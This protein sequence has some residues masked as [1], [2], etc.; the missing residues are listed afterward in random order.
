MKRPS[1]LTIAT[2][3]GLTSG[4]IDVASIANRSFLGAGAGDQATSDPIDFGIVTDQSGNSLRMWIAHNSLGDSTF[5][6]G[7]TTLFCVHDTGNNFPVIP[8]GAKNITI[9][10]H[11]AG[12]FN[13]S[14]VAA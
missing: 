11:A 14:G 4:I 7:V 1:L 8:D 2:L 3:L 9:D 10:P 6:T 13:L 5:A 12:W